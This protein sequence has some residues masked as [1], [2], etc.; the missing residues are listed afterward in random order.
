VTSDRATPRRKYDTEKLISMFRMAAELRDKMLAVGFTDNGG[1]IHSAERILNILG[2]RLK[3]PELSHQNNLRRYDWAERSIE[4]QAALANEG[5]VTIEHV[6]PIRDFTREAIKCVNQGAT[7]DGL[8]QFIM[9]KYRLVLLT[10][11]EA[12]HLNKQNRSKMT[13]DRLAGIKLAS[14]KPVELQSK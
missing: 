3:Y 13:D 11:A 12:L 2:L 5:I 10:R 8:K 7:D 6:S 4:A 14:A 1:A 9:A